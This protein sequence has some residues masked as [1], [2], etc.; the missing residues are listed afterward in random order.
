MKN[1][2]LEVSANAVVLTKDDLSIYKNQAVKE[3]AEKLKRYLYNNYNSEDISYKEFC[4]ANVIFGDIDKLLKE[5]E[6]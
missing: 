4:K 3:F 2:R 1:I 6:K 5:Y